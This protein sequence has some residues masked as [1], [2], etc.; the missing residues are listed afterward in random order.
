MKKGQVP[1]CTFGDSSNTP[2]PFDFAFKRVG[3]K[4]TEPTPT[5]SQH[6]NPFTGHPP[7]SFPWDPKQNPP[8]TAVPK[9]SEPFCATRK[10]APMPFEL[11]S[12]PSTAVLKNSE[13]SATHKPPPSLFTFELASNPVPVTTQE[14]Y[15]PCSIIE[16][17]L[18]A[19][20]LESKN[21]EKVKQFR[22][23]ITS[24]PF[25]NSVQNKTIAKYL[26]D[27]KM[28]GFL[29]V[30]IEFNKYDDNDYKD[31]LSL[32]KTMDTSSCFSLMEALLVRQQKTYQERYTSQKNELKLWETMKSKYLKKKFI[33]MVN[34]ESKSQENK[35]QYKRKF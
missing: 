29:V 16:T 17:F 20:K 33:D 18:E 12:N 32:S 15:S 5:V 9:N 6:I 14:I 7:T 13:P 27:N 22:D 10:P 21:P 26:L 24:H 4:R 30:A 25:A 3:D 23:L 34:N 11:A 31:I 19:N 35:R 2:M 8:S 28:Y 1:I